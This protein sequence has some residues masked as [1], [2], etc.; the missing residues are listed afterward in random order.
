MQKN[1]L[2][3]PGS[4]I[5]GLHPAVDLCQLLLHFH[6]HT[7]LSER[8]AAKELQIRFALEPEDGHPHGPE[9]SRG[10]AH[11]GVTAGRALRDYSDDK[12]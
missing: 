7:R 8:E 11:K 4:I 12:P 2:E 5:K 1:A 10:R 3:G 9:P 6:R